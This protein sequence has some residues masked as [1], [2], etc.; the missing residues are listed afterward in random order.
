MSLNISTLQINLDLTHVCEGVMDYLS[1]IGFLDVNNSVTVLVGILALP[2]FSPNCG[3]NKPTGGSLM[4]R[5]PKSSISCTKKKNNSYPLLLKYIFSFL[6]GCWCVRYLEKSRYHLFLKTPLVCSSL[7]CV[8]DV[9]DLVV[10]RLQV[11][12]SE[13]S[14]AWWFVTLKNIYIST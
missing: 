9:S 5:K 2:S 8:D 7:L 1:H 10:N 6:F 12:K 13:S 4:T 3:K 11:C 14:P